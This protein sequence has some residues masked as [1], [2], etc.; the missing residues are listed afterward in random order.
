[1]SLTIPEWSFFL[2]ICF[3]LCTITQTANASTILPQIINAFNPEQIQKNLPV[4]NFP[5]LPVFT[6]NIKKNIPP[7]VPVKQGNKLHFKLK[8]VIFSGNKVFSTTELNQ[9]FVKFINKSISV[10]TFESLVDEITAKYRNAG[11]ILS[12]AILPPQIVKKG[13]VQ[14]NILEGFISDVKYERNPGLAASLLKKYGDKV[15]QSRPFQISVLEREMLLANDIPGETVKA[16]ITPSQKIAG[17]ADLSLIA[18]HQWTNG[19]VIYNNYGTRYLG[20]QQTSFGGKINSLLF[21]G[22]SNALHFAVT[23][24]T[25]QLQFSEFVHTQPIGSNGLNF[26]L[27]INYTQTLPGFVLSDFDIVGRSFSLYSNLTYPAIR[28]RTK[29][30]YLKGLVN[31]QNVNATIL[32]SPFYQDR[33]RSI[34]VGIDFDVYDHWQGANTLELAS[35]HGFGIMG[36]QKHFYQSR[37]DGNPIFSKLTFNASRLQFLSQRFSIYL[38]LQGQYAFNSLLANEQFSYGGPYY[39]RGYDSAEFVADKGFAGKVEFRM[40]TNLGLKFLQGVQYYIFYDAGVLWNLDNINLPGKQ[41]ATSAGVGARLNFMRYLDG[42]TFIAK[43]LTTKDTTLLALH[44]N[45]NL[46]RV[47]FQISLH[48]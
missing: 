4:K 44:Q 8:K 10:N 39:G 45:A 41:S 30:L 26:T 2:L 12:Q 36:A 17:G 7:I 38:G 28:T 43:P 6:P 3:G 42:E 23:S 27:G 18:D 24:Q 1:M 16:V 37:P 29:N 15:S 48:E 22:D 9:I 20:P 33:S 11:Y 14:I 31:Y 5:T 34:G 46:A 21:P 47:Y 35:M 40:Q 32:N 25:K 13:V 19:Y